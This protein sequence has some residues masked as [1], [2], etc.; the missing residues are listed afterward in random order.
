MYQGP[1]S[2]TRWKRQHTVEYF[3]NG[4]RVKAMRVD[5][6]AEAEAL[7]GGANGLC[8]EAL[9]RMD[10]TIVTPTPR[11][12]R[13]AAALVCRRLRWRRK[14][15]AVYVAN[16]YCHPGRISTSAHGTRTFG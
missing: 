16:G 15:H 12:R 5:T 1:P 11:A 2:S 7:V 13:K 8:A 6:A 10:A 4:C 14:S 3:I 9:A